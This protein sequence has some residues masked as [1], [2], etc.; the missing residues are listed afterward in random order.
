MPPTPAKPAAAQSPNCS[1]RTWRDAMAG[2]EAWL[3]QPEAERDAFL[4]RLA[5]EQPELLPRV[6]AMIEADARA[7]GQ[8]FLAAPATEAVTLDEAEAPAAGQ[9]LGAWTLQSPI[10]SGGMGEVWRALRSDGLYTG[11]AAV[12]LQRQG[13]TAAPDHDARFAREAQFLARVSH[14]HVAQLLDAGVTPSGTRYLVLEYVQGAAI[15]RWC[16]DRRLDIDAR[17]HLFMQVCEAVAFAHAQQVVHRDLKPSN[18]LVSE[19][20]HAK[21]LDFGVAKL[22]D[23]APLSELTRIGAA[24]LT[25]EYAAPEQVEGQAVSPATDVY[26]LGVLLFVLLAGQ[27]PYGGPDS[28]PAQLARAIVETEPL[29]LSRAAPAPQ[30]ARLRGD[31]E[32]IVDKALRKRPAERYANAQALADDIARHLRHEP[33]LARVPTLAYRATKFA[34]RHWVPL[35]A[36]A[37]LAVALAAGGGEAAALVIALAMAA[38]ISATLWQA[39]KARQEARTALAEAAKS[40]AIKNY[41]VDLF[42]TAD[43]GDETDAGQRLDL[44]V[45][46]LVHDG[47]ERLLQDR[48]LPAPVRLELLGL[49]GRL[50]FDLGNGKLAQR[51]GEPALALARELHGADSVQALRA[52]VTLAEIAP[53]IGQ[54]KEGL[55]RLDEAIAAVE[56]CAPDA[57]IRT[58]AAYAEALAQAGALNNNDI[59]DLPAARRRLEAATALFKAH[60]PHHRQRSNAHS[61]LGDTLQQQSDFEGAEREYVAAAA[62]IDS[63]RG[64]RATNLAHLQQARATLHLRL[65]EYVSAV[66]LLEEALQLLEGAKGPGHK[67][68]QQPRGLLARALH[69]IGRRD[70]GYAMVETIRS[71]I[72]A[73]AYGGKGAHRDFIDIAVAQMADDENDTARCRE[74]TTALLARSPAG[75]PAAGSWTGLLG[76]VAREE[77]RLE[78]ARGLLDEGLAI[79][80]KA[81]GEKSPNADRMRVVRA[82]VI[83]QLGPTEPSWAA[84]R[85]ELRRI[86]EHPADSAFERG[87]AA[88][89]MRTRAKVGAAR[90][91]LA[92]GNAQRAL[93]LA[94]EALGA[95]PTERLTLRDKTVISLALMAR[96]LAEQALGDIAAARASFSATVALLEPCQV[97]TSPRLARARAALAALPED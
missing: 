84:T 49:L 22:L 96:G 4:A 53:A 58:S 34:R 12:K 39:R 78:E 31:L 2:F 46:S 23:E 21:L 54:A 77:G 93:M 65:G 86:G 67:L 63:A 70:E 81:L 61:W 17:L 27:R 10:G 37:V 43:T 89:N 52:R 24:G 11:F 38:G 55:K 29:R 69:Q 44:S 66:P 35:A 57:P 45:R 82:E 92:E 26:S 51:L 75:S 6:K 71:S 62:C 64:D 18:I 76:E 33:V 95:L 7:E 68:T 16:D 87:R 32:R 47:G 5:Q 73:E 48:A 1:T 28:T 90:F 25:P 74:A 94:R 15:D 13:R 72:P 56:R 50:N 60:H 30:R 8:A 40:Q 19:P 41:V 9:R 85:D 91:A 36:A 42:N 88:R 79:T 97:A 3:D 14:P 59:G 80:A 83:V 20:G